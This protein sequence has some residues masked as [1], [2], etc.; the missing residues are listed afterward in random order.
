VIDRTSL[1]IAN[2]ALT[3]FYDFRL[4]RGIVELAMRFPRYQF[5]IGRLIVWIAVCG[6]A[7]AIMR[8]PYGFIAVFFF[9][10]FVGLPGPGFAIGRARG[11]SGIIG[12]ALSTSVVI[13][14]SCIPFIW[15]AG[16]TPFSR[17]ESAAGL[18][19]ALIAA[20]LTFLIGLLLSGVLYLLVEGTRILLEPRQLQLSVSPTRW[21]LPGDKPTVW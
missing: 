12:G 2:S 18:F 14:L 16:W 1:D 7:F 4:L 17:F 11:G 9:V 5:T 8:M 3:L 13:L 15:T 20:V 10:V 19:V 21:K 6:V